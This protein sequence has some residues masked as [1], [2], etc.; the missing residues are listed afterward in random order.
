M[1]ELAGGP[2]FL[3]Q[4]RDIVRVHHDMVWKRHLE[5]MTARGWLLDILCVFLPLLCLVPCVVVPL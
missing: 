5:L 1:L 2:D 4:G 3:L